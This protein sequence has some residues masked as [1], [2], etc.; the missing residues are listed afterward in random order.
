MSAPLL[1]PEQR[2]VMLRS[3]KKG[4]ALKRSALAE[5]T[6]RLYAKITGRKLERKEVAA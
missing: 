2:A 6:T 4:P 1:T 5:H 3:L